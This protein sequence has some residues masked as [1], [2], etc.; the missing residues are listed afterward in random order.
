MPKI[1]VYQKGRTII[2]VTDAVTRGA[3]RCPVTGAVFL[4]DAGY[5]NHITKVRSEQNRTRSLRKLHASYTKSIAQ[6]ASLEEI[7]DFFETNPRALLLHDSDFYDVADISF[8]LHGASYVFHGNCANM[9][10]CPKNGIRNFVMDPSKPQSYPGFT[11]RI[12]FTIRISSDAK[13][14][15]GLYNCLRESGIHL[16]SGGGDGLGTAQYDSTI[17]LDDFPAMSDRIQ[18]ERTMLILCNQ[19]S[20]VFTGSSYVRHPSKD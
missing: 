3:R 20:D 4:T 5:R 2:P 14:G 11:G 13:T 9:H 1:Q 7:F 18:R 10:C 8:K 12:H 16:R 17:F 6:L 15:F 19:N